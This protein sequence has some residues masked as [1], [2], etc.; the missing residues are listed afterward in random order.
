M[1][2]PQYTTGHVPQTVA[3]QLRPRKVW[4]IAL[5]IVLLV[6]S[7]AAFLLGA[8]FAVFSVAFIDYCPAPC[9]ATAAA[10]SQVTTGVILAIV[11]LLATILT[12]VL[13]VVRRRAWWVAGASLLIIIVGWIVGFAFYAVALQGV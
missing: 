11:A 3:E 12:I 13:L 8:L 9:S 1:S 6:L 10:G 7:Y 5:S 2:D 4:D